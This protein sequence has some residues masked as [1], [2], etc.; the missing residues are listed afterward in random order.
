MILSRDISFQFSVFSFQRGGAGR[1]RPYD[2]PGIYSVIFLYS[3]PH[4][5]RS[6]PA[7]SRRDVPVERPPTFGMA[8]SP[9]SG[10]IRNC[11]SAPAP[12]EGATFLL[13]D[14]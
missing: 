2:P 4:E 6:D 8:R 10:Y 3:V 14:H 12:V 5:V 1:P 9:H 7:P 11:N 13:S